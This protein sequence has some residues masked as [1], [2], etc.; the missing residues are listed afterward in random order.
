M[1][2][3]KL[4]AVMATCPKLRVGTV[5]VKNKR[6]I[7]SGFNGAPAGQPHCTEV[8]CMTFEDEGTSCR[9][10]IHSEHNAVLQNSKEVTGGSLYTSYLPCIDCMKPIIAAGISEVVYENEYQSYKPRYQMAKEL[11]SQAGI[12]LRKI[13]E[14]HITNLLNTYY[15]IEDISNMVMDESEKE[16][17]I[18][19]F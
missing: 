19:E 17:E 6:I 9:R 13:P 8:G 12:K 18:L 16:H 15:P 5:I 10:V 4:I 1:M 11:A 7:S 14:V 3:A 2:A